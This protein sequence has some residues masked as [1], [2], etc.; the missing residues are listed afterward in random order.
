MHYEIRFEENES[1]VTIRTFG[2]LNVDGHQHFLGEL[3][4]HSKWKAGMNVLVDHR[5]ASLATVTLHDIQ[6]VSLLVKQ[7]K[8]NL[9]SG[10]RCAIVLSEDAEFTRL[11]CGRS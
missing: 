11:Q 8:D 5:A 7:L 1:F 6:V 3:I 2:E 4:T 10:G 9:G